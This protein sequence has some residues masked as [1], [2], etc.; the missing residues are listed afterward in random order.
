VRI[1]TI[2]EGT[3]EIL[4]SI[5]GTHRWRQTVKTKGAFYRDMATGLREMGTGESAALAA[6]AMASLVLA[7]HAKKLPREQWVMFELAR[8]A[9]EVET[10]VELARK[11]IRDTSGRSDLLVAAA[12]LHGNAAARDVA[13]TGLR[14]LLASGRFDDDAVDEWRTGADF[15][16]CLASSTGE[17]EW[18]ARVAAALEETA[19]S[20]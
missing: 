3:S 18:M 1:T 10:A 9:T 15:D 11:A 12:R 17:M 13:F 6:D 8:L 2:Y 7:C 14:L 20:G 5:I 16:H 19:L 4:Q